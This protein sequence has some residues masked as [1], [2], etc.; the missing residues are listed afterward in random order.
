MNTQQI[1]RV[2]FLDFDGVTTQNGI[3]N[4]NPRNID[5]LNQIVSRYDPFV[6]V[7]SSHR[8]R[9]PKHP[10]VTMADFLAHAGY[11]GKVHDTTPLWSR[12][13]EFY[14]VTLPGGMAVAVSRGREI[15]CWLELEAGVRDRVSPDASILVL[16]DDTDSRHLLDSPYVQSRPLLRIGMVH[17]D[18]HIG[19]IPAH[20][21]TAHEVF[22][23]TLA[24]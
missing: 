11:I 9:E 18:T 20:L 16:D 17:P 22:G 21:L 10:R 15:A 14:G 7:S 2:L 1:Q 4:M 5:I 13:S 19:L 3:H 8:N 12:C 6:V 23:E 24:N